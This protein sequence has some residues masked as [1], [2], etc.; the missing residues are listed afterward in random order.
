MA[1]EVMK[2][3]LSLIKWISVGVYITDHRCCYRAD[4]FKL[5]FWY[6]FFKS[7]SIDNNNHNL[8]D[9]VNYFNRFLSYLY[10]DFCSFIWVF[11]STHLNILKDRRQ[12]VNFSY[13]VSHAFAVICLYIIIF[14]VCLIWKWVSFAEPDFILMVQC[15][16]MF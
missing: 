6:K 1:N 14:T 12:I 8:I 13:K 15:V 11:L 16:R 2:N 9:F 10:F 3:E 5:I 4:F 7:S